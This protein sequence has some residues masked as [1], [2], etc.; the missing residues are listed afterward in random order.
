MDTFESAHLGLKP[1]KEVYI[2]NRLKSLRLLVIPRSELRRN[3]KFID[4]VQEYFKPR[5]I[6]IAIKYVDHEVRKYRD[7]MATNAMKNDKLQTKKLHRINITSE[8][9]SRGS[10]KAF[11]TCISIQAIQ[12]SIFNSSKHVMISKKEFQKL[13]LLNSAW[14]TVPLSDTEALGEVPSSDP[15]LTGEGGCW[16]ET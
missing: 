13:T 8:E 3:K 9:F 16:G 12:V 14:D 15:S 2:L 4:E 6:R 5:M 11:G 10:A 1:N 7:K